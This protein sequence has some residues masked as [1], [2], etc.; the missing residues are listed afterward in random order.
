MFSNFIRSRAINTN[1]GRSFQPALGERNAHVNRP[2]RHPVFGDFWEN[3]SYIVSIW[4]N[5]PSQATVVGQGEV[6]LAWQWQPGIMPSRPI[7]NLGAEA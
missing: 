6:Q 7:L 5:R 2:M 1:Y 4:C 3:L